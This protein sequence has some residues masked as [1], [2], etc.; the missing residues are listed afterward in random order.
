[1]AEPTLREV[2]EELRKRR[3]IPTRDELEGADAFAGD[4]SAPA[5]KVFAGRRRNGKTTAL[6]RESARMQAYIIVPTFQDAQVLAQQA[7]ALGLDIPFPVTLEEARRA[8]PS[9]QGFLVHD[10]DRLLESI[11]QRP[12]YG[13]S[14]TGTPVTQALD[15]VAAAPPNE[16]PTPGTP[17]GA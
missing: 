13:M 16:A 17:R 4:L 11:L 3:G 10:V 12:V 2:L 15:H 8:G 7:R 6:L 5:R 1:M 14:V 9:A